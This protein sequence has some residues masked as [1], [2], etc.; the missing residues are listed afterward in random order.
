M[1]ARDERRE[2]SAMGSRGSR[3]WWL[4][5]G[6]AGLLSTLAASSNA[7]VRVDGDVQGGGG[8]A[9]SAWA[10][11]PTAKVNYGGVGGRVRVE[12][13]LD[14]TGDL[15]LSQTLQGAAEYRSYTIVAC[16]DG[17]TNCSPPPD[18]WLGGGSL[19]AGL[20]YRWIELEAGALLTGYRESNGG[21]ATLRA[22]PDLRL[23]LG[24]TQGFRMEVG[25]GA[26]AS[27]D[28]VQPGL[29]G[30]AA[31]RWENGLDLYSRFG[32]YL[33]DGLSTNRVEIGGF[34]PVFHGFGPMLMGGINLHSGNVNPV[35]RAGFGFT[36]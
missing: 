31:Y 27:L 16:E 4:C 19:R 15:V 1:N 3:R 5:A 34:Y 22:L 23:R 28:V 8:Q 9:V 20:R 30:G 2:T 7:G 32:V 12:E 26:P 11:G 21:A 33:L 29:Y 18:R 24:P 10:C 25:F 6:L 17:V 14:E 13:P 35:G 36:L